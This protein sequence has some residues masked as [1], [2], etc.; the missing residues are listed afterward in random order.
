MNPR[1]LSFPSASRT[2]S[3]H[4][5]LILTM[6]SEIGAVSGVVE[7][8]SASG[9]R[10]GSLSFQ[11][12]NNVPEIF[13]YDVVAAAGVPELENGQVR[14]TKTGGDGLM[15]G[16]LATIDDEGRFSISLGVNP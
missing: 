14:V 13:L 2:S 6:L 12:S 1:V 16:I 7:V 8:F 11:L 5:N 4:S 3:S 15:W 10:L 9:D